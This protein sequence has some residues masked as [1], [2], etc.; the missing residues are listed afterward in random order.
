MPFC[1]FDL[2]PLPDCSLHLKNPPQSPR[3]L[4][5]TKS[6][7]TN[8]SPV[9]G[10]PVL[11]DV[12]RQDV[13]GSNDPVYAYRLNNWV[14]IYAKQRAAVKRKNDVKFWTSRPGG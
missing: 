7:P 5:F 12:K 2:L 10:D 13:T 4:S 11:A 9:G 14:S 8:E 3:R 1:H 6:S